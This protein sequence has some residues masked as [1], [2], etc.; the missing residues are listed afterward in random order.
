MQK[1]VLTEK[2][3][4]KILITLRLNQNYKNVTIKQR[5]SSGIGP[6]TY[7][8]FYNKLDGRQSEEL[9]ITDFEDW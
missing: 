7:A 8:V 6:N 5:N 4:A 2:Q 1:V 9:D 3:L